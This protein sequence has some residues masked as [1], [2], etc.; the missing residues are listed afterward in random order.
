MFQPENKPANKKPKRPSKELYPSLTK[1]QNEE[2][3]ENL[4]HYFE[5]IAEIMEDLE[6]NS[7]LDEA[8]LRSQWDKRFESHELRVAKRKP[9]KS[10]IHEKRRGNSLDTGPK[11]V[12]RVTKATVLAED[13]S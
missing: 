7:Q 8:R 1:K 6:S 10:S 2:A 9:A 13:F 3:V 12:F 11:Q 5:V 4:H